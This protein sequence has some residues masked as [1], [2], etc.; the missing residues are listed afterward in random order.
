M[1]LL[2]DVCVKMYIFHIANLS[3]SLSLHINFFFTPSFQLARNF[4]S[5]SIVRGAALRDLC[6]RVM[7]MFP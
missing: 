3:L 4:T 6:F 7:C 1:L 5:T 2:L